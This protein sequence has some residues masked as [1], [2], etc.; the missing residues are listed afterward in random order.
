[1]TTMCT[2]HPG[3]DNYDFNAT[4]TFSWTFSVPSGSWVPGP[5]QG[6]P[7]GNSTTFRQFPIATHTLTRGDGLDPTAYF[8]N[9]PVTGTDY[10][11][12]FEWEAVST[13]CLEMLEPYCHPVL[14]GTPL[15]STTFPSSFMPSAFIP[16]ETPAVH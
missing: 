6:T 16:T 13:G 14:T 5:T 10:D 1:M 8:A 7:L 12:G 4:A 3:T 15:S 9:C 11:N 2:R